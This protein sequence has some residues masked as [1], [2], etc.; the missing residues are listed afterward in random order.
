M[1]D[2]SDHGDEKPGRTSSPPPTRARRRSENSLRFWAIFALLSAATAVAL[3]VLT[4]G[5]RPSTPVEEEVE[6]RP[7]PTATGAFARGGTPRTSPGLE[8]VCGEA[9]PAYVIALDA[10][11]K[12]GR[13]TEREALVA[14]RDDVLLGRSEVAA[15]SAPLWDAL[16]DALEGAVTA[17]DR[18]IDDAADEL[19]R[20]AAAVNQALF[21]AGLGYALDSD[22]MTHR[23]GDTTVLLFCF[24]VRHVTLYRS[25]E[26]VIPVL[27][28]ERRDGLNWRYRLL[29]FAAAGR[30][31]AVILR[32][33]LDGR[34]IG[35]ILPQLAD[36]PPAFF[37]LG[38][39]DTAAAWYRPVAARVAEI[40][41]DEY[42]SPE[43]A[44]LGALL[45]ARA[46]LF[47][48]V[49]RRLRRRGIT[50]RE[51]ES[52]ALADP[53][54]KELGEN[55]PAADWKRLTAMQ[56]DIAGAEAGFR[57]AR[58]HLVASI[59]R[60]EVQ[61]RLDRVGAADA[62]SG[63]G[64]IMPKALRVYVGP[65]RD[66]ADTLRPNAAR[67]LAELSAYLAELARDPATPRSN[68]SMLAEFLLVP[69]HW[70]T[71]ECYA[72]LVIFAELA[73]ELG[74]ENAEL[75]AGE[76]LDRDQVA[77]VFLQLTSASPD[78]LRGAAGRLWERLFERP[79]ADLARV[80]GGG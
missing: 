35:R 26:T 46:G 61:H 68:L 77:R 29:G 74:P 65:L 79:L 41:K 49:N 58:A 40:I 64:L 16:V 47:A 27:H 60:H 10:W 44:R 34:L 57:A 73:R 13:P 1:A 50:L 75:V 48:A 8:R 71:A 59:E 78:Q 39:R 80:S 56:A 38:E 43:S 52:L 72:A 42:G 69:D 31:E 18:G 15:E 70:G 76:R 28:L 51:P 33:Q 7:R 55:M 37:E 25:G 17:D 12:A 14:A 67:A 32:A 30:D 2:S 66:D 62:A 54:R 4:R 45:A 5:S 11:R 9:I 6:V 36:D 24:A 22:V 20:A 23:G 3:F 53:I 19:S 21:T 63:V